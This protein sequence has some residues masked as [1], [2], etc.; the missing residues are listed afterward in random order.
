MINSTGVDT[1]LQKFPDISVFF[2]IRHRVTIDIIQLI[3][4]ITVCFG[5]RRTKWFELL[6]V[7][8]VRMIALHC[9]LFIDITSYRSFSN[10][11]AVKSQKLLYQPT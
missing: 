7:F 4:I 6:D 10:K 1:K 9:M 8:C 11:T 2:D 5:T 3:A